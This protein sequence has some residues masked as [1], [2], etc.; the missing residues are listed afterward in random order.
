MLDLLEVKIKNVVLTIS[1]QM[2]IG[3]FMDIKIINGP[4]G[5]T[6]TACQDRLYNF[7]EP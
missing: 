5:T 1:N 4:I 7:K 2:P 6:S 3:L